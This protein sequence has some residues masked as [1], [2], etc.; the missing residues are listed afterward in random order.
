[1]F[2]SVHGIVKSSAN[3][4]NYGILFLTSAL[5]IS[6]DTDYSHRSNNRPDRYSSTLQQHSHI[7]HH[8]GMG[9]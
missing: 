3:R 1:V 2:E 4:Q 8:L 7:C 5:I 9:W 6:A